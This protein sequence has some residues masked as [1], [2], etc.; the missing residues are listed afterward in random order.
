MIDARELALLRASALN[1]HGDGRPLCVTVH[2]C[3]FSCCGRG[4]R[5]RDGYMQTYRGWIDL[6]HIP[7]DDD[8][9]Q[10]F[11]TFMLYSQGLGTL[12]Y[13]VALRFDEVEYLSE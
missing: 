2:G 13:V 5:R 8:D 3:A 10:K 7:T 9:K 4:W 6:L 12:N 11:G 1:H